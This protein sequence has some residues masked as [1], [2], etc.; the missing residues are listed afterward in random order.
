MENGAVGGKAS[1]QQAQPGNGRDAC[2]AGA[3][4]QGPAIP[5]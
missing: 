3:A 2:P 5:G 1:P 4:K